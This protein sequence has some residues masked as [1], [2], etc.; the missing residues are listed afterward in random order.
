LGW[1]TCGNFYGELSFYL[2][3]K[4]RAVAGIVYTFGWMSPRE[5]AAIFGNPA[6]FFPPFEFDA[7]IFLTYLPD[8][9][10]ILPLT[11]PKVVSMC[12]G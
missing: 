2:A 3:L 1:G 6:K 8:M 11:R 10:F 5:M 7:Q 9:Q 4:E 12:L